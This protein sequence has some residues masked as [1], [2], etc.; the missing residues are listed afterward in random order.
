MISNHS[1]NHYQN[2]A[3]IYD[4]L[5]SYSPDYIKFTTQ[6]IIQYLHLNA[7]DTLVDIGCG[8]GIYSKEILHQIQLQQPIICVDNSA[9]MV[10]KIPAN[11]RLNPIEMDGVKFSQKPGIY[12]KILLKEAIHHIKEKFILFQNLYQR[13]TPGGIFLLLLWPPTIEHPLFTEALES[14]EKKQPHYQEMINLL[15][16]V[17]FVVDMDII[18]Y[19]LE[20]PKSQYFEM[21]ENCYMSLL[22]EFNDA[23]LAEGL[24]EIEEK[25]QDKSVLKFSDR[26]VFIIAT[27]SK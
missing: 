22:S 9:E 16:Q 15:Q 3:N 21:V 7:T 18:E 19:P 20:L 26:M 25:Y 17:G 23:E 11:S 24:K 4:N 5:W 6:K 8:T 14:Y 12:N 10:G 27:K 13:L 1:K 2:I